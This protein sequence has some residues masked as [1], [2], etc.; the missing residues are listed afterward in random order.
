MGRF[1]NGLSSL[2]GR[3]DSAL[4]TLEGASTRKIVILLFIITFATAAPVIIGYEVQDRPLREPFSDINIFRDR[5]NTILAGEL[6]YSDTEMETMTPPVVNYLMT[7]AI[8]LGDTVPIWEL[9][10]TFFV[11]M[12]SIVLF[13]IL[14]PLAGRRLGFA[15]ALTYAA[16]PFGWYTCVAMIQ[17]DAIIVV[18]IA[19]TILFLAKEKWGWAA[20][21]VSLGTMTKMF[22]AIISPLVFLAPDGWKERAKVAVYGFGI[23]LLISLPFLIFAFDGFRLFVEFYLL[24]KQPSTELANPRPITVQRGMSFWRF[25]AVAGLVVPTSALHL[26]FFAAIIACWVAV[27]KK[28]IDVYSGITLCILAIFILYSKVH[29]G[30]H[31]MVLVVLIPWSLHDSR[32]M[33]SLLMASIFGRYVHLAWRSRLDFHSDWMFL[34]ASFLMWL[35]WVWWAWQILRQPDFKHHWEG[36]LD[37]R[38]AAQTCV[39]VVIVAFMIAIIQGL[40]KAFTWWS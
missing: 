19:L 25:L 27:W 11:F 34:L 15:G 38:K 17:D 20:A 4:D 23:A 36:E 12:T 9:W 7:P 28:K 35:Y 5:A 6:L 26:S 24:G 10:F 13:F 32:R 8:L 39:Q 3:I 16:S 1:S 14:E 21:S 18:F 37:H 40:I 31:T 30:Y 22:P 2:N 33:W 29:Y